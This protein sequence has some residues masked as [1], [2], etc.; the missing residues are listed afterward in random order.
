VA[1]VVLRTIGE[2]T[3]TSDGTVEDDDFEE[4]AAEAIDWVC[5]TPAVV[6]APE[7]AAL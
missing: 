6:T 1:V 5:T 4:L 3:A 2:A 7:V